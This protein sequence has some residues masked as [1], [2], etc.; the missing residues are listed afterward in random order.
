[1]RKIL[2]TLAFLLAATAATFAQ[3][4]IC[5]VNKTFYKPGTT[6][7]DTQA[8]VTVFRVMLQ[9]V[10]YSRAP[11]IFRANASG[12]LLGADGQ[13]GIELP[14]GAA[15]YLYSAADVGLPGIADNPST[16]TQFYVRNNTP[17]QLEELVYART[18]LTTK[19]GLAAGGAT[20]PGQ[21][22][23]GTDGQFLRADSTQPL[24]LRY[25]TLTFSLLPALTANR[26][27]QSDGS[28][29]ITPSNVTATELGYLSGVTSGIQTQLNG[30]Q[31]VGNYITGLSGDG[32]ATG[33]GNVAFTLA[34]V[35]GAPGS[36]GSASKTLTAT[37]NSKGLITSLAETNIA[38]AESQVTNLISDL[39]LKAPLASPALTGIPTAPTAA[40]GT[41][42][43]QLASTAFV[44][45]AIAAATPSWGSII[46]TLSN[47]TDLQNA[48]NLKANLASPNFTGT[49]TVPT[50]TPGTNTTQAAS[51]AF[52]TAA[53]AALQLNPF[54]DNTDLIKGSADATKLLRFEV[55]GF[56]TGT[57]RTLT[58]QNA[59]YTIAGTNIAQTYTATQTFQGGST[60]PATIAQFTGGSSGAY[61]YIRSTGSS[62]LGGAYLGTPALS[63]SVS[64]L[65]LAA[66]VILAT[67]RTL[68]IN[69]TTFD[70]GSIQVAGGTALSGFN[71]RLGSDATYQGP[72]NYRNGSNTVVAQMSVTGALGL[73]YGG[74]AAQLDVRPSS[75]S[76]IGQIIRLTSGQTANAFEL[77]NSTGT[78]L[79][80]FDNSG[81]LGIGTNAPGAL[82]DV[83][84]PNTAS[85]TL[86]RFGNIGAGYYGSIGLDSAGFLVLQSAG[87]TKT[88]NVGSYGI[89]INGST[90]VPFGVTG[91]AVGTT[92]AEFKSVNG[93]GVDIRSSA[94]GGGRVGT[95]NL[96]TDMSLHTNG[97]D[98]VYIIGSSGNVGVG[99]S[100]PSVRLHAATDDA[101]TNTVTDILQLN[102]SSSGTPAAS[103]GTGLLF[104]GETTTTDARN[105]A[106]IQSVWTTATDA[107]RAAALQFQTLTGAGSL[108]TQMTID[109]SGNVGIGTTSPG[110]RLNISNTL[111]ANN[112]LT[113]TN[114]AN[115]QNATISLQTPIGA[116]PDLHLNADRVFID[117]YAVR[118]P[119]LE[120]VNNTNWSFGSFNWTVSAIG[121][122]TVQSGVLNTNLIVAGTAQDTILRPYSSSY[123]VRLAPDGGNVIVGSGTPAAQLDVRPAASGTIGQVIRL[124]SG[125][126]ASAFE[127]QNSTGTALSAFN[128]N[129]YLGLGTTAPASRLSVLDETTVTT[130]GVTV[131]Q[132]S[133]DAAASLINGRKARGS[134]SSLAA[135]ASGDY[136]M[137][138]AAQNYDGTS[139]L[140]NGNLGYRTTGTVTT[141]SVPGMWYFSASDSTSTDPFTD[142]TVRLIITSAG[143]VGINATSFGAS[144]AKVLAIGNGTAPSSS[145]AN[146][147]Q[148]W[149]ESGEAKVRDAS[150]NV[151]TISPH[152]FRAIPNGPS[153]P[154]AWAFHSE[155]NNVEINVDML[156]VVRLLEQLTGEKLV[157]LRDRLTGQ[158]ISPEEYINRFKN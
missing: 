142:G 63:S 12:V 126:T 129:G 53:L 55:D 137:A 59:N 70:N 86:A 54:T 105:M 93:Y 22:T 88:I 154:L 40:P 42:T 50:A 95:S 80:A 52:V 133:S 61:L 11:Q 109:G 33:P 146:M 103:F 19:G 132:I 98:R 113:L 29:V 152:N 68:A 147:I 24:G 111:G 115:S 138:L 56:T 16:G 83:I 20:T 34:T 131:S 14:C 82:L 139:W 127:V 77:Q 2:F 84:T 102:H 128:A 6:Q 97:T 65:I 45:A 155:R 31:A 58:P 157:F 62:D 85:V 38:I 18:L 7:P 120:V 108:T 100:S 156:R 145:P 64:A 112:F 78:G 60:D 135:V 151:T 96:N 150:G 69:Q 136:T 17:Q 39:A 81:R 89:G 66:N 125:Q 15:V 9:N 3:A 140:F 23:P 134:A 122:F 141:N 67:G 123:N 106:R 94:S 99:T 121:T 35:N 75:T 32:T 13:P 116:G 71:V 149:S 27:L 76:T 72:F 43:T 51:T 130:R 47:Q 118:L 46:G 87:S 25:D 26:A 79:S 104:T 92:I 57:T 30:K 114:S 74:S 101:V 21:L 144:A 49:P 158:P 36:F 28:G 73:G 143:N 1:M 148:L 5:R 41:N 37:V 91:N 110:S 10:A 48:L 117:A 44:T 153:E 4:P 124:A 119:P 90:G 8:T 107:S